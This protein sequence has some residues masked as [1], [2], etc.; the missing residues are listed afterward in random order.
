M[1]RNN[2]QNR[3]SFFLLSLSFF[4]LRRVFDFPMHSN[5][6][7]QKNVKAFDALLLVSIVALPTDVVGKED[8]DVVDGEGK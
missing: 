1:T 2:N 5:R 8:D 6:R 4:R 3:E 7:F